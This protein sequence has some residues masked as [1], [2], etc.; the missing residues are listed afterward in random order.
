MKLRII[1][2]LFATGLAVAGRIHAADSPAPAYNAQRSFAQP[3]RENPVGTNVATTR[4]FFGAP[5][6]MPHTFAGDRDG[7][8]C[9]ECHARVTRIEKRQNAMVCPCPTP[10]SRSASNA[11]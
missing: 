3:I 4:A 11:T 9:L 8:Y 7:R 5:P 1:G 10:S 6:V 2:L